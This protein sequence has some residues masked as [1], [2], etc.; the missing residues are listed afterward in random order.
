MWHLPH[1]HSVAD[2]NQGL[3][4][5]GLV[6]KEKIGG[7]NYFWSFPAKEDRLQQIQHENTLEEIKKLK[8]SIGEIKTALIEAKRGRE[9]DGEN[10]IMD[11]NETASGE[12]E[13]YNDDE[14]STSADAMES[15]KKKKAKTHR[16]AI[17]ERLSE[18]AKEKSKAEAEASILKENDPQAL[19]NLEKELQLV[20]QAAHRWTDNIFN[21]KSY[22]VKKRGMDKKEACKLLGITDSFDCK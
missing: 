12:K 13:K 11:L 6:D 3:V 14:K 5:D 20:T 9:E 16:T 4:D 17:L 2:V 10:L 7:T 19:A 15:S 1:T 22:L 18:L 8:A 21:A